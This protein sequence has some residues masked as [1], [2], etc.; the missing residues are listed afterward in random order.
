M[1]HWDHFFHYFEACT[2]LPLD[3]RIQSA[4]AQ[5]AMSGIAIAAT[6]IF[7]M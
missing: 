4:R 1:H 2:F 6:V 5:A 3:I 7:W